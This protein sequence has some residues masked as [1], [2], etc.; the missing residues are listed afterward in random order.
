MSIPFSS[1]VP[2]LYLYS[3]VS[4]EKQTKNNKTGMERQTTGD[5]PIRARNKFSLLPVY[6][7]DDSGL[8]AHHGHNLIKGKLGQFVDLCEKGEIAAGS[9]LAMED[10][11][12]FTRIAI[13]AAHQYVNSVLNAGVTIYLWGG[14]GKSE[15]LFRKNNFVDAIETVLALEGAHQY[16]KKLSF[17]IKKS[18]KLKLDKIRN[19]ANDAKD[20][21]GYTKAVRG[22]G[23]NAW[24]V[25]TSSGYVRPHP[26]Y[27][28]IA[29]E[30]VNLTLQGF[31][32]LKLKQYLDEKGYKPPRL[33]KKYP[34]KGWGQNLVAKFH[35]R[36]ALI[37]EVSF[38][39][40]TDSKSND[41]SELNQSFND[42]YFIADYYPAVCSPEEF[43][44][45]SHIKRD[46]RSGTDKKEAFGLFVG[47]GITRCGFCGATMQTFRSK[48]ASPY[49][50]LRYKCANQ[51]LSDI[52]CPS[53]T[54]DSK[55]IETALIKLTGVLITQ[56]QITSNKD[57]EIRLELDILKVN[58]KISHLTRQV[59]L[60]G[61]EGDVLLGS[62][63]EA[64]REKKTLVAKY[65]SLK[66]VEEVD[67][68]AIDD[69]PSNVLDYHQKDLRLSIR[70]K[71]IATIKLIK[72]KTS[73]KF[74]DLYVEM[75]G[76]QVLAAS[77]YDN[78]Y[79]IYRNGE[80]ARIHRSE[81]SEDLLGMHAADEWK[82]IDKKG[83]QFSLLNPDIDY[84][85]A[86]QK[87][88]LFKSVSYVMTRVDSGEELFITQ[89]EL[90]DVIKDYLDPKAHFQLAHS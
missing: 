54:I 4:T 33:S 84:L 47:H 18:A 59:G 32:H 44:K 38:N 43:A 56:P 16:S 35:T 20:A 17:R 37:G 7:F 75:K 83:Q 76:G 86:K 48:A 65:D 10:L 53:S 5:G 55:V 77:I 79:L 9:V 72:V 39:L 13:T 60:L 2:A 64:S 67:P 66:N 70:E 90:P 19:S 57:E 51:G 14:D 25:D 6:E 50:T 81:K 27:W 24:W 12:R 62:L 74:T 73:S 1:S 85:D 68:F 42:E 8:S 58:E 26:Y 87:I 78:K 89:Y 63:A 46:K 31:G 21:D 22:Y 23:T 61:S 41:Y 30:M 52:N 88:E 29:R 28:D 82:G 69:I 34:T 40:K 3:R 45:M 15:K 36:R 71:V 11:D 49:E 80:F